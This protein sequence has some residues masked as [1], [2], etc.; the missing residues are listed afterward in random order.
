MGAEDKKDVS[1]LDS[2]LR[3]N[4]NILC[5][6]D[7]AIGN[8]NCVDNEA[9]LNGTLVSVKFKLFSQIKFLDFLIVSKFLSITGFKDDSVYK[10]ICFINYA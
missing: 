10:D 7:G 6:N 4:D 2:R 8:V 3:G 1:S 9:I 5:G